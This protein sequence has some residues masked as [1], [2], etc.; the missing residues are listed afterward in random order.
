MTVYPCLR[1]IPLR[2]LLVAHATLCLLVL[3]AGCSSQT[4]TIPVA[5]PVNAGLP[6]AK[7]SAVDTATQHGEVAHF[8]AYGQRTTDSAAPMKTDTIFRIRSMTKPVATAA[9]LMLVDEGKL[10]L[11]DPVANYIPEL[12]DIQ[13]KAGDAL[14]APHRP[15]TVADLMRHTAGLSYGSFGHPVDPLYVAADPL[16]AEDLE[17]MATRLPRLVLANQPGQRWQ[18]SLSIEVLGLVIER[19]SGQ[20]LD[21]FLQERIFDPLD[22]PDTGFYCPAEKHHRLAGVFSPDDDGSAPKRHR[23]EDRFTKPTRF[24]SGG[25]G[26]VSTAR[27]Y[28]HFLMMVRGGGQW[29]GRRLLNADT[30]AL[31]ITDHPT[32][33]GFWFR[34]LGAGA[35]RSRHAAR[36]GGPLRLERRALDARLGQ[37]LRR[38]DGHHPGT[39]PALQQRDGGPAEADSSRPSALA[40]L[41]HADLGTPIGGGPCGCGE[42]GPAQITAPSRLVP[43][44]R[45]GPDP[46][47]LKSSD[48][49]KP[50]LAPI[51]CSD[52]RLAS[53]VC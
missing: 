13:V 23:A 52:G 14:V 2:S 25:G 34:L 16:G 49:G 31:M 18:Y 29:Q 22:M 41:P 48:D 47:R 17:D 12:K 10:K 39:A 43:G 4:Q 27:D 33:R 30:A 37:P 46:T 28:S 53:P 8:K 40:P 21:V 19:V 3:G 51:D 5:Q 38:P 15:M 44:D 32:R 6:E 9:A 24:F 26:L 50:A 45:C 36:P 20:G 7:R 1:E 42:L 11:N 35:S